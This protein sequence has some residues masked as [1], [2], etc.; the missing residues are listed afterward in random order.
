[1]KKQK[2][3]GIITAVVFLLTA[4]SMN[5]SSG[6]KVKAETSNIPQYLE[7][8]KTYNRFVYQWKNKTF[9]AVEDDSRPNTS[10]GQYPNNLKFVV[11][12]NGI[13]KLITIDSKLMP[14]SSS[15][16]SII[17]VYNEELY[18]VCFD[19]SNNTRREYISKLNFNTNDISKVM[20]VPQSK[21]LN[22]SN[23]AH[24]YVKKVIMD[25]TGR[26]SFIREYAS[27]G[28]DQESYLVFINADKEYVL[29]TRYVS[30]IPEFMNQVWV[31]DCLF[32]NEGNVWIEAFKEYDKKEGTVEAI[33]ALEGAYK[34]GQLKNE[35][36]LYRLDSNNQVTKYNV[37]SLT[38]MFGV[39]SYAFFDKDNNFW[40]MT[41]DYV[42]N[43]SKTDI[44]K[45]KFNNGAVTVLEKLPLVDITQMTRDANGNL[46]AISNG[47]IMKYENGQ[48]IAKYQAYK[49][50][51]NERI[52]VYDDN[53]LLVY[54]DEGYTLISKS[55]KPASDEKPVEESPKEV[56]EN[57]K[58]EVVI[59]EDKSNAAVKI[60]SN[61]LQKD[62]KNLINIAANN[63]VTSF[64][65]SMEAA[66]I[67]GGSG[68]LSIDA[69]LLK[70]EMPFSIVDYENLGQGSTV[71]FKYTVK[72]ND[73]SLNSLK[74]IGKLFDFSLS[75]NNSD[76]SLIKDIHKFNSG[77]VK[78]T[79][80]LTQEELKSLSS[81]NLSAYYFNESEGIWEKIGGSLDKSNL[82]FTFETDHF[83]KF[84]LGHTDGMLP[85][86]G[87][88]FDG[89]TLAVIALA[90][91]AVGL[92]LIKREDLSIRN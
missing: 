40:A 57:P 23:F 59:S 79:V 89:F 9:L 69:N 47:T 88:S 8:K 45:L 43:V 36:F 78:V 14:S 13:E 50:F 77:K 19:F 17:G 72:K 42:D 30:E 24:S 87:S 86:T 83:S 65:V 46:W 56:K 25:K 26:F 7:Y 67:N 32:D 92:K 61:Q 64:S 49:E 5:I 80:K 2:T 74:S 29:K 54:G 85:Q 55:S 75:T 73:P 91:I 71:N 22:S 12:E 31:S 63:A 70:I 28:L 48:M 1:M 51:H 38:D 18:Y 58:Y 41:S 62:G 16:S 6:G 68:N 37:D 3:L 52:N 15:A 21:T 81:D 27:I 10:Q 11:I 4:L 84:T 39:F 33:K 35:K 60:D 66:A 76:Q 34:S 82:T 90:C 53:N 44:L 20:D